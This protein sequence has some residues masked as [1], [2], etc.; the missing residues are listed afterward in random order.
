MNLSAAIY[1]DST[2]WATGYP[3]TIEYYSG[4]PTQE[5]EVQFC[6]Y[7]TQ[8]EGRNLMFVVIRGSSTQVDWN[9]NMVVTEVD[10]NSTVFHKGFHDAAEWLLHQINHR[11]TEW[12]IQ[13]VLFVGHSRGGSVAAIAHALWVFSHP[14]ATN[15]YSLCFAPAPS[16]ARG[17]RFVELDIYD[18]MF[19]FV[20]E[21][22][23][24]PCFSIPKADAAFGSP[25]S[26]DR[27]VEAVLVRLNMKILHPSAYKLYSAVVTKKAII[28]RA[29][30]SYQQNHDSI[31]VSSPQGRVYWLFDE[32]KGPGLTL[33]RIG[34][35]TED[36]ADLLPRLRLTA[37]NLLDHQESRYSNRI[38]NLGRDPVCQSGGES[39]K[40]DEACVDGER[41]VP[42]E[43]CEPGEGGVPNCSY[44]DR[45]DA[46][47]CISGCSEDYV[48]ECGEENCKNVSKTGSKGSSGGC[49]HSSGSGS[50]SD[51]GKSCAPG[52]S[53]SGARGS[54]GSSRE[55]VCHAAGW[56]VSH[57]QVTRTKEMRI[58]RAFLAIN[59]QG[60]W[61]DVIARAWSIIGNP[62][63]F[64]HT[65][66]WLGTNNPMGFL[67]HYGSYYPGNANESEL[68]FEGDGAHFRPMT[69]AEFECEY[70]TFPIR[71]LRV[72]DPM[73]LMDVWEKVK[74]GGPWTVKEY[75][76]M[77][78][79]C[80]HFTERV[81]AILGLAILDGDIGELKE[82]PVVLQGLTYFHQRNIP[83]KQEF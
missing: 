74:E 33:S 56:P 63:R 22:D 6:I 29:V 35:K 30:E 59:G 55:R 78:H 13:D 68:F 41:D 8:L 9:G 76:W 11:I 7:T 4:I 25:T 62:S 19:S 49:A 37:G 73:R 3:G 26:A 46:K 14:K 44:Y 18:H 12:G 65:A 2:E 70:S 69:L 64:Y 38:N 54:S 52:G 5:P 17:G 31:S 1:K 10:S 83:V 57:D 47:P 51:N 72:Q 60:A 75:G 79:N 53:S 80:Q 50:C 28:W 45:R 48:W 34:S 42:D 24:V 58:T 81:G 16:I 32:D 77:R 36:V 15:V 39:C 67:L 61:W 27:L 21:S 66:L 23:P 82:L 71:E 40:V 20:Y 43:Y